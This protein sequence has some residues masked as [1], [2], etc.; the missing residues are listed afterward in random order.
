[1]NERGKAQAGRGDALSTILGSLFVKDGVGEL[2]SMVGV[3]PS[4]RDLLPIESRFDLPKNLQ[5]FADTSIDT[6]NTL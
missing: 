3:V 2:C 1:M 6:F 5:C 4:D